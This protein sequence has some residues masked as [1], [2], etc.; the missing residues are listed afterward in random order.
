MNA[1]LQKILEDKKVQEYI[2]DVDLRSLLAVFRMKFDLSDKQI[3]TL[4]KAMKEA[5]IVD[6]IPTLNDRAFA[7]YC[8]GL[9]VIFIGYDYED[10]PDMEEDEK[11]FL[12]SLEGEV[13]EV[14]GCDTLDGYRPDNTFTENFTDSYWTVKFDNGR[15]VFATSGSAFEIVG[16]NYLGI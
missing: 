15:E 1:L 16:A 8:K 12:T 9:K 10:E 6:R 3:S 13:G 4:F 14:K 11:E 5:E 2:E 7:S